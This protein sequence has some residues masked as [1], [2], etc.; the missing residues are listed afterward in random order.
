MKFLSS[1]YSMRCT[2]IILLSFVIFGCAAPKVKM[3]QGN[4]VD[5]SQ[6]AII[7]TTESEKKWHMQCDEKLFLNTGQ[8]AVASEEEEQGDVIIVSVDGSFASL[9]SLYHGAGEVYV[10]PGKHTLI[11]RMHWDIW[12]TTANLW[13][14]VEPGGQYIIKG[15]AKGR[16]AWI[17]IE[18]ERTGQQVGGI[19]GSDD[20]PKS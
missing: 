14:I 20:E 13:L 10:L 5:A 16:R 3:Y 8:C 2:F 15:V 19:V 17:W 7:R 9:W 12:E 6:Q 4:K 11:L 1:L 18:N